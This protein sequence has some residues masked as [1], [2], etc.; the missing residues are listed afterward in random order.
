M[1]SLSTDMYMVN[2]YD[3]DRTKL[4]QDLAFMI[5][6]ANKTKILHAGKMSNLNLDL[7]IVVSF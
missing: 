1:K 6:R 2:W 5:L 7:F 4:R 3:K